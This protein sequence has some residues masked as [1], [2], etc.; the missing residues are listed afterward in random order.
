[1][2]WY[3]DALCQKYIWLTVNYNDDS[4]Q[5]SLSVNCE[6]ASNAEG[7]LSLLALR[8]ETRVLSLDN[9]IMNYIVQEK[10]FAIYVLINKCF[11]IFWS[12][13]TFSNWKDWE[14]IIGEIP[15][16]PHNLPVY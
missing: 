1:M 9:T 2:P 14:V 12:S 7:I 11:Y 13:N 3:D 6:W 10:A 4:S 15:F 16:F 5:C 8:P